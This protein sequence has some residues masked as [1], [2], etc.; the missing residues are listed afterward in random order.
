MSTPEERFG[1]FG[2]VANDDKVVAAAWR[3]RW[4]W[5]VVLCGPVLRLEEVLTSWG[6]R[7]AS[8]PAE[9]RLVARECK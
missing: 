1:G 5:A 9:I 6:S 3:G 4:I 8:Q 7:S 2:G